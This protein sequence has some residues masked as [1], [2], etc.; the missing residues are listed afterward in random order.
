MEKVNNDLTS[1]G[2][3]AILPAHIRYN[4]DLSDS[5]KIL[6][7]EITALSN[8]NGYCYASNKYLS[9][10]YGV[11]IDTISRRVNKL[12]KKGFVTVQLIK[13]KGSNNIK[14]RRIYPSLDLRIG[15]DDSADR[16]IG[17]TANTPIGNS[18]EVNTLSINNLNNNNLN[19]NREN[20]LF[21]KWWKLYPKKTGSKKKILPK[22]KKAIKEVG[23]DQ[24]F[25]ATEL[26]LKTQDEVRFICGPEVF[27]N[28]ERYSKDAME[29]N[30]QIIQENNRKQMSN[31]KNNHYEGYD[32]NKQQLQEAEA[33]RQK[34][35]EEGY[36][37]F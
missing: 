9:E 4:K 36:M 5:E 26:Y 31:Y 6:F 17:E 19:S 1:G 8:K 14:E 28:Q 27:I 24:F 29:T 30:K 10:I 22:F 16:G 3:Y 20:V 37:P 25:K 35:V 18:A 34:D 12:K 11:S 33:K 23:E 15:I 32:I 13:E 21:E 7:C 2:N